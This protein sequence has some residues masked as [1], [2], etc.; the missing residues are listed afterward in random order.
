MTIKMP[1]KPDEKY[2]ALW[3]PNGWSSS[4]GMAA[5]VTITKPN[6]A[7]AK[8]TTDSMASDSKPTESVSH[9]A[10]VL[11]AM[12]IQATTTETPKSALGVNH[13]DWICLFMH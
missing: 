1:S 3:W 8:F 2:S 5:T 13:L 9:Q 4:A 10:N 11:R 12:V 6:T 7:L